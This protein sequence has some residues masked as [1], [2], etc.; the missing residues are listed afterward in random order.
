M[1]AEDYAEQR[2]YASIADQFYPKLRR[3]ASAMVPHLMRTGV[4]AIGPV[5]GLV[6]QIYPVR[7]YESIDV[8]EDKQEVRY[9]GPRLGQFH[10][11][12]V[13]GLV[14]LASE[15]LGNIS[16]RFHANDFLELL[17]RDVCT[18][19]VDAL[20]TALGELR[21]ATF[22]VRHFPADRGEVFGFIS[23]AEWSRRR[24]TVTMDQRFAQALHFLSASYVPL[25]LRNRLADG[26]QTALADLL[27]ATTASLFPIDALASMWNREPVQLGRD[28]TPALKRLKEVGLLR[29]YWRT[30]GKFRVERAHWFSRRW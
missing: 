25:K 28:L 18:A 16:L 10:K 12:V 8:Q 4:F 19:N 2:F 26:V 9:L 21:A 7:S 1:T 24:F 15:K 30:R 29:E 11:R 27:F 6:D 17:G 22:T 23:N 14:A 20:R 5:S 13:L 3:G